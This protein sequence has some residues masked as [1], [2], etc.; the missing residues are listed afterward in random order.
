MQ[1]VM[2]ITFREYQTG[3]AGT[4]RALNEQWI[5][6]YFG[7][8][9]KDM[10]ILSDPERYILAPGGRIYFAVLDDTIVGCCALIVNGLHSYE[11]AKM[12]VREEHRNKGI[13][14]AL[15]AH[16]IEAARSLD[17]YKLT[18]ETNSKLSNAIH[19]Y[20]S[21]GFRHL[22]PAEVEPSP[23]TRANVFMELLL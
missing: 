18:L 15:L 21:L 2:E 13:G 8:E 9:P 17:A 6:K 20:E 3:D 11:V 1:A 10:E 22:D 7:L 23:Y 14:K 5:A 16:V 19:V 4:F 12:A